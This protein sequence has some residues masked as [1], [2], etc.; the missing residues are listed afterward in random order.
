ML[1]LSAK[2]ICSIDKQWKLITTFVINITFIL[3]S[4]MHVQFHWKMFIFKL[5]IK[6]GGIGFGPILY[7]NEFDPSWGIVQTH[8]NNVKS[9]Y[10]Y[11][12]VI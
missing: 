9:I 8:G 6:L 12:Y 1:S 10:M 5:S 11:S 3:G 4:Y 7:E 2:T